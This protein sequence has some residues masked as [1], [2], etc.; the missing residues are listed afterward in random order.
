[1]RGLKDELR[2]FF[3]G[4]PACFGVADI[5][6]LNP[7]SG[8]YPRALSI[9]LPYKYQPKFHVYSEE[10]FHELLEEARARMRDT[11]S[12]LSD[13]LKSNHGGI[14]H[15]IV[16]QGGQ[17]PKTLKAFFPHK[18]AAARAGLGW[19][20]KSS[21]LVTREHGPRV[22]LAT[23]LVD[24]DI[25]A[26]RPIVESEC[27]SCTA[28]VKACPYICINDVNWHSGVPREELLDIHLCNAKREEMIESKGRKDECGLCL[29]ACPYGKD[30]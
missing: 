4:E 14:K 15:L 5:T 22:Y 6:G 19:I 1:M 7:L 29:L 26:D 13:L 28:C 17:D 12:R 21:L 2:E 30:F 10:E 27:G 25:E 24:R 20:G 8:E 16:P 9:C 3:S 11:V 23:V 18:F